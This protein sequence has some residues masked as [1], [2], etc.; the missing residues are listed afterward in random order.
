M[1]AISYQGGFLDSTIESFH[2]TFG[3]SSFGR[4]AV[5]RNQATL[6]YDL[7]GAQVVFLEEPPRTAA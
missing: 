4:P 3:F 5:A 2:D 6:I 7:K 1:S